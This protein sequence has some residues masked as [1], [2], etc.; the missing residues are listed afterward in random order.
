MKKHIDILSERKFVRTMKREPHIDE[1]SI[2]RSA[3]II[4]LKQPFFD[5]AKSLDLKYDYSQ[6]L[7][8]TDVYL[9][10][11]LDNNKQLEKW[12]KK[13]FDIIFRNLINRW[14]EEGYLWIKQ[15]RTFKMFKQW[16]DYSLHTMV[17]DTDPKVRYKK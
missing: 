16:F 15:K 12:L 5:W 2:R 13:N 7:V 9:L 1:F 14:Q 4:K 3:L 10:P 17:Y 8:D 6:Y 11:E